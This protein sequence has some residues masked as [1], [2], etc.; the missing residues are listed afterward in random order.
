MKLVSYLWWEKK[1]KKMQ[2]CLED[3]NKNNN[4]THY[5][6]SLM[7]VKQ[8][9]DDDLCIEGIIVIDDNVVSWNR[10]KVSAENLFSVLGS[11]I[12]SQ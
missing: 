7:S 12:R 4:V 2:L 10:G 8:I 11:I 3:Y 1:E 6:Y 5:N 9:L